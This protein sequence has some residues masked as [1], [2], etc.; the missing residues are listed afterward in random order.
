MRL[1]RKDVTALTDAI[2][3]CYYSHVKS[4]GTLPCDCT[5]RWRRWQ[6]AISPARRSHQ[7]TNNDQVVR[8]ASAEEAKDE[9]RVEVQR[10]AS[11]LCARQ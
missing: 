1:P 6:A 5:E 7:R 9:K 8:S 10:Q 4:E 3:L 11:F 2:P